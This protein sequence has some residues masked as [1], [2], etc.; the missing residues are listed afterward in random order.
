MILPPHTDGVIFCLIKHICIIVCIKNKTKRGTRCPKS[1][2]G[3]TVTRTP[4]HRDAWDDLKEPP[5]RPDCLEHYQQRKA[6]YKRKLCFSRNHLSTVHR[7]L[8]VKC[9]FLEL[10]ERKK[11]QTIIYLDLYASVHP[12]RRFTSHT[13]HCLITSEHTTPLDIIPSFVFLR[14]N[15]G[16]SFDVLSALVLALADKRSTPVR[17]GLTVAH[18]V[19]YQYQVIW[20]CLAVFLL[21]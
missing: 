2:G 12:A 8:N 20:D 1:L 18:Y 16:F 14:K 21:L 17:H 7:P 3:W 10:K 13:E 4:Y 19:N 15:N 5:E 9:V 6:K 11:R